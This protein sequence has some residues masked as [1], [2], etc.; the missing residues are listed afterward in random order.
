M[1]FGG[2]WSS[3][4]RRDLNQN[5]LSAGLCVF[6]KHIKVAIVIEHTGIHQLKLGLLFS[7]ISVFFNQLRVRK[8]GLRIFVEILH[9]GM[10]RRRVKIEVVFFDVFT[11]IPFTA[12]QPEQALF[13]NRITAVPECQSETHYLMTIANA[14]QAVFIP[15]VG[16]RSG[17]IMWKVIPGRA[18]GAVIFAHRAPRSFAHVR[19]P[20]LP[21]RLAIAGFFQPSL[22]GG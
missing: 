2:F 5:V 14:G 16:A 15:T 9:V 20:A 7:A 13:Q 17:V 4:R 1:N 21:M 22:F 6:Y 18:A 11:V 19:S 10:R 8:F 12:S 3:I